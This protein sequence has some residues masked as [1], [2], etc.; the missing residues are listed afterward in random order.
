MIWDRIE[1]GKY[2]GFDTSRLDNLAVVT[3][4]RVTFEQTS[5]LQF[6]EHLIEVPLSALGIG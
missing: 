4:E 3:I 1:P 6:H 5:R 2:E